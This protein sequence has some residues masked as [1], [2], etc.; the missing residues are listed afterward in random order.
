MNVDTIS[1]PGAL[2]RQ[3]LQSGETIDLNRKNKDAANVDLQ[4]AENPKVQPEEFLDRI[5]TITQ[6]GQY[7]VRFEKDDTSSQLVVKIVDTESQEVLR[8]I[9]PEDLLNFKAS[10]AEL[11]GNVVNTKG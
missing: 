10:F 4:S 5:K 6:D 7:S 8:Q 2:T 3:P 1:Q 9:P 11:I